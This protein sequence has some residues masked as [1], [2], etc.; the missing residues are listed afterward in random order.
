M[1]STS[2]P[3][4]IWQNISNLLQQPIQSAGGRFNDEMLLTIT[5]TQINDALAQFVT[6]NVDAILDFKLELNDDWFRLICT[7]NIAG[8][9]VKVASNFK[10]VHVQLDR[11]HQRLVFAQQSNTE[12]LELHAKSYL[13]TL[14]IN[15]GVPI[16][17]KVT[18][19]DPLGLILERIKLAHVKEN[20]F[21]I[22]IGRWLRGNKK[23]MTYLY[24]FQINFGFVQPNQ[25]LLKGQVNYRDLLANNA[26]SNIITEDDNPNKLVKK[27]Q[28]EDSSQTESEND[29]IETQELEKT[30]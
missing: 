13:Y 21:Y 25:L 24:K 1:Q 30:A 7:I 15:K 2:N 19:K 9:F 8:I 10:L 17:R 12:I 26:S 23:I 11:H 18:G 22:D 6:K 28:N 3:L 27:E 5:E 4:H 29:E 14:A 20:V 16:Y